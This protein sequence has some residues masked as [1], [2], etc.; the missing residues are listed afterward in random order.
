ML[1]DSPLAL[2]PLYRRVEWALPP[3]TVLPV[4]PLADAPKFKLME[5]GTLNWVKARR[6]R[7][8]ERD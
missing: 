1:V 8:S 2:S 6:Y 7:A 5:A 4:A 3:G